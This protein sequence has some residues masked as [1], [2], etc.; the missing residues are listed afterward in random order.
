M[1]DDG[2][3]RIGLI[4]DPVEQSL[5]PAFQQAAFD[6]LGL[7]IRYELWQTLTEQLPERLEEIRSGAALGAHVTVPHKEAVFCLVDEVS[8]VARRAGAVNTVSV[9]EG[10]L[11]GDNTDVHGFIVPLVERG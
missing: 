11:V 6:M 5:S 10:R 7:H 3:Q 2:W 8:P 1:N 9:S 4:G